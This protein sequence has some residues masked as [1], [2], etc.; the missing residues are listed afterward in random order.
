MKEGKAVPQ[1]E[2]PVRGKL[3]TVTEAAEYIGSGKSWIYNCIASGTLP[4]PCYPLKYGKRF[5]SADLDDYLRISKMPAG[6][7]P[8]GGRHV[9]N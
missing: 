2:K 5:D 9:G 4:F 6:A 1:R 3:L 7:A 8:E